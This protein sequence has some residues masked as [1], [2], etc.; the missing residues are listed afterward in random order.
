MTVQR[1]FSAVLLLVAGVAFGIATGGWW[2]QRAV[3]S[4]SP[5]PGIAEAILDDSAIRLELEAVIAARTSSQ[6]ETTPDQL[7]AF[8]EEQVMTTRGGA[9]ELAAFIQRAHLR[10]IGSNDDLVVMVPSELV[11]IVR[12]ER[13]YDAPAA[14]IPIPV[15]GTLSTTRTAMRWTMLGSVVIGL[16]ALALGV[17]LRPYRSD[18]IRAL[19]ELFLA[20]AASLVVIGWALPTFV[21]PAI[22]TSTWTGIAPALAGRSLPVVLSAA[23]LLVGTGLALLVASVNSERRGSR[24]SSSNLRSY[25]DQR[26]W[27]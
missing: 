26:R 23:I 9:V 1:S 15:V 2:L 3:F 19:G 25:R 6:L 12:D 22:D 4:P 7:V 5:S 21:I 24:G 11:R 8:L 18:L 17:V 10:V 13:A 20:V 14:T 16:I 27:S